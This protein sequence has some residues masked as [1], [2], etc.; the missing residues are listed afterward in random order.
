NSSALQRLFEESFGETTNI[1]T[2][3]RGVNLSYFSPTGERSS[4]ANSKEGVTFLYM[5]GF[6]TFSTNDVKG[7]LVLLKA[8]ANYESEFHLASASLIIGGP[9]CERRELCKW[10]KSLNFPESVRIVGQVAAD[11]MPKLL[12]SVDCVLVPSTSEGL[13]NLLMEAAACGKPAIGTTVGGI[14]EVIIDNLTGWLIP[15]GDP[16]ALGHSMLSVA[17]NPDQL[18]RMGFEAR[19]NAEMRFDASQYPEAL[20]NLYSVVIDNFN[21]A[22]GRRAPT[23]A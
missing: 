9:G 17:R 13:P 22:N 19:K 11:E 23:L 12:R 18:E 5:G 3:Y 2:V 1:H 21:E 7:G 20:M 8:W 14:P 6:P 4:L 15:P 16:D 10:R